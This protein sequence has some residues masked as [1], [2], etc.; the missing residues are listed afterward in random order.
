MTFPTNHAGLFK[1]AVVK[2]SLLGNIY[3][4]M[5]RVIYVSFVFLGN[6]MV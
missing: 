5:L 1:Q 6:M 2:T 4:E 3:I